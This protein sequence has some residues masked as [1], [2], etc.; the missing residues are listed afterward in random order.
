MPKKK[1]VPVRKVARSA[2]RA[3]SIRV[4]VTPELKT[5]LQDLGA[6]LGSPASKDAIAAARAR[7]ELIESEA[8]VAAA[9]IN[10]LIR[11]KAEGL[12]TTG[13]GGRVPVAGMSD[14]HLFYALAKA[15]RGEY[16]DTYSR[17]VEVRTLEAE[18]LRRLLK[19]VGWNGGT[20]KNGRGPK[21]KVAVDKALDAA[22]QW[23]GH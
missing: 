3:S 6:L 12:W 19:V 4:D 7:R 14:S 16:P 15:R 18:V 10:D 9:K 13:D 22:L 11:T 21:L 17:K 23:G 1:K 5:V 2:P 8:V 20:E